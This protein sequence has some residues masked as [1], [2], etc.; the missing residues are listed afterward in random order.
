LPFG[1]G[2]G[3]ASNTTGTTTPSTDITNP[4]ER[5]HLF[6]IS[7]VPVTGAVALVKSGALV[8]RYAER[9]TGHI[10][11]VDPVSLVKTQIVNTTV[12]KVYEAIF[13]PS[14]SA[15]IF[16]TLRSD[17]ETI[18]S[19][20]IAL[21][22]PS[23]TSTADTYTTK[24]S[25]LP[26]N[27]SGLVT[28]STTI[29]YTLK[30]LPQI[31]SALFDGTK[32]STLWSPDFNNWRLSA[33]GDTTLVL[34]TAASAG[35][36]GYSYKLDPKTGALTKLFGPLVGLTVAPNDD[37]SRIA[38]SYYDGSALVLRAENV[39]SGSVYTIKPVTLAEKCVW[40]KKQRSAI[41]CAAPTR[42]LEAGEPDLWYKG[43][44]HYSD[45]IWRLNTDTDFANV[46]VDPKKDFGV[47]I[48]AENLFLSPNEDYLFFENRSD[49]SLWA[50]KLD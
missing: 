3:T 27:I 25:G 41:Y 9:A 8:V 12:P 6:K 50:L 11:D 35:S 47:D 4:G 32:A 18:E 23:G 14:G 1:S 22:P 30:N 46:A 36:A 5:P 38:Y 48:D 33:A 37:L 29:F 17:G 7:D 45:R 34:T 10:D 28:G 19:N 15:V 39:S 31:T 26:A 20:S 49:L 21:I 2:E 24:S 43:Q 13:K 40:S 42:G 16:R 44:T